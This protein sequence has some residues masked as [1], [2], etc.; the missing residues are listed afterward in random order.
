[1]R[2]HI[3]PSSI[4]GAQLGMLRSGDISIAGQVPTV[5]ASDV[6]VHTHTEAHF[7]L[8]TVGAY[9]ST[10]S[11]F[12]TALPCLIYNPPG[13][14]HRDCFAA[15]QALTVAHFYAVWIGPSSWEALSRDT[16]LPA[17]ATAISGEHVERLAQQLETTLR[18]Q[19]KCD[20]SLITLV[21]AMIAEIGNA[22][23]PALPTG[24][25]LANAKT[26]LDSSADASLRIATLAA[27]AGVHP[28]HFTRAFRQRYGSAPMEYHLQRR[29]RYAASMLAGDTMNVADVA[30]TAGFADQAHLSRHF[31]LRYGISPARY[32]QRLARA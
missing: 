24:D 4:L 23:G 27:R 28:G 15:T 30:S 26:A 5:H 14:E 21:R 10:A 19:D 22:I 12:T 7:I 29:I 13:T 9:C 32:R 20:P 1:M 6:P 11:G 25:W 31:A 16:T 2:P 17:T 8:V 18:L 3:G